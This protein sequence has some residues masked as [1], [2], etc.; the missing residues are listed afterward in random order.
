LTPTLGIALQPK[1]T[2]RTL[3]RMVEVAYD[4]QSFHL[5][6]GWFYAESVPELYELL[7]L[8]L[9]QRVLS[10]CRQGLHHAYR[11]Q[12]ATLPYLRGQLQLAAVLQRP[13]QP[14]LPC[15]FQEHTADVVDNQILLW[16]LQ[17]IARSSFCGERS[18]STVRQAV[19]TLQWQVSAHPVTAW[20]CRQRTYTRLN[21]DYAP[22]HGLCAFFLEHCGPSH[23]PGDFPAIPFVV[24]MARLYERFVAAWL[25]CH[26][27]GQWRVQI[28][29]THPISSDQRFAIDLVLY[30]TQSGA[31]CCV[32]DTKYKIAARVNTADVAQVVA[33]AE[34]KGATE[35]VLIYPQPPATPLDTKVG[36]I[37]IRTL[38]F[39]VDGD[40]EQQGNTFLSQLTN[41]HRRVATADGSRGL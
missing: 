41:R 15:R 36:N 39:G 25:A 30:D 27:D 24:E 34:A 26:L 19:R 14:A 4:L 33:Y 20:E 9:A 10:R 37:H 32:M 29:E 12:E 13:V 1:V 8:L 38:T 11:T 5:F 6:A 2:L 3:L 7:A 18:A 21:R 23:R 17:Q 22:L 35:A 28:Q 31:V 16:T 40:L